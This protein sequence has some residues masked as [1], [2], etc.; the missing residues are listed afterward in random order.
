[1]GTSALVELL[2]RNG[3]NRI[4]NYGDLI[5]QCG[6]VPLLFY[7]ALC[8]RIGLWL[9]S[10]ECLERSNSAVCSLNLMVNHVPIV[11][12]VLNM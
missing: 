10:L 4:A 12:A 1:M 7:R 2:E 3:D 6:T 9:G 8:P 5:L 11:G